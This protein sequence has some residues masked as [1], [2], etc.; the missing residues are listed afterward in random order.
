VARNLKVRYQKFPE[1]WTIQGEQPTVTP[2]AAIVRHG[3][4]QL[5]KD[6][7]IRSV[8]DIDIDPSG[9]SQAV[10]AGELLK[11]IPFVRAVSGPLSRT[12][13]T[14]AIVALPHALLVDVD[15][16]LLPWNLGDMI[17]CKKADVEEALDYYIAHP[18]EQVP[19]GQ[20]LNDFSDIN[21]QVFAELLEEAE[22]SGPILIVCQGSNIAILNE[23]VGLPNGE[24][25][26]KPGGVALVYQSEFGY[27][28]EAAHREDNSMAAYPSSR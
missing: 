17:G 26:V 15:D 2:V 4:T 27:E 23:I 25:N 24:V 16:R 10:E 14:A 9:I 20:S 1:G 18:D 28:L 3:E 22:E 7:M 6:N 21:Y 8:S 11:D 12:R 19:G 5:N 13:D